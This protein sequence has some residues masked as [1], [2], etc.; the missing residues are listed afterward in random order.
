MPGNGQ[1]NCQEQG[2]RE[3]NLL[4]APQEPALVTELTSGWTATATVLRAVHPDP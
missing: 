4:A 2:G 1:M 3:L